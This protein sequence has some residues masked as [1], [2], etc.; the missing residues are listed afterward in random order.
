MRVK[1]VLSGRETRDAAVRGAALAVT[2]SDFGAGAR[3]HGGRT[4]RPGQH[5]P[6]G[7]TRRKP[8]LAPRTEVGA[9]ARLVPAFLKLGSEPLM[10]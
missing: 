8:C 4:A 10:N 6:P 1:S 3:A 9:A 5:S 7:V 2:P